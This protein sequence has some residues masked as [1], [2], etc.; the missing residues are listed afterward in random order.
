[1][2]AAPERSTAARSCV[3]LT[4]LA[5]NSGGVVM[6]PCG[7][8][9]GKVLAQRG[10][11]RRLG[12][13]QEI[14]RPGRGSGRNSDESAPQ[15]LKVKTNSFR[16]ATSSRSWGSAALMIFRMVASSITVASLC[17]LAS[18][19]NIVPWLLINLAIMMY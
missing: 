1:M 9:G 14:A 10:R 4:P 19:A 12:A 18:F 8:G 17:S 15:S 2:S 13:L 5:S 7:D 11:P 16:I 3:P 6:L